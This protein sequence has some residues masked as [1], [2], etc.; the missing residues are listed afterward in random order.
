MVALAALL[1]V[2]TSATAADRV[3][4]ARVSFPAGATGTE[5]AGS[6][7]GYDSVE[8]QIGAAAGQRMAVTL[9][10]PS[11]AAYFNVFAPGEVPGESTALFIGA[12][13]GLAFEGTLPDTGDYIV[14]VFLVRA[15]ARRGEHADFTI[16]VEITGAAATAQGADFADGLAGGPDLWQVTGLTAGDA[17]NLREQPTTRS[18]VLLTLPMDA[19]LRN[20][21]CRMAGGQRWC[22]VESI[23]PPMAG[24]VAGRYLREADAA[25]YAAA[26]PTEEDAMVPGTEFNA[27]GELPCAIAI[28]QPTTACP[29]GVTREGGGTA[30]VLVT[31]PD[32]RKR[33]IFF[34]AGAATGFDASAADGDASMTTGREGDLTFVRVGPERY[35]IPDIVPQGD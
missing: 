23:A 11:T 14:Q 4:R 10:S 25:A 29:F 12:R 15:A 20:R 24:W 1:A 13:D 35:E 30:T 32:G 5:V 18:A 6:V 7:T 27:T 2:A 19:V 34:Q 26:S 21:G 31:L 16:E 28:G 17:L 22:Q 33:A 8:Y 9:T 3:T